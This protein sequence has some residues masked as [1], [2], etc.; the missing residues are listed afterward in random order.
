M[1]R[2][3][4]SLNQLKGFFSPRHIA[5][6]GAT[7][8]NQ[9]FGNIVANAIEAGFDGRFYPV[10]PRVD[11]IYGV[12]AYKS[13]AELPDGVIDCAILIV[14]SH[15]VYSVIRELREKHINNILL[16][17]SGFS[18]MGE[19]GKDKQD[20][21]RKYCT[22]HRIVLMGPNCLGFMNLREKISVFSGRAVEGELIPGSIGVVG[23]S[24]A[25][26]EVIVTKI[27]R[28][29]MGISLYVTTGNEAMILAE[30]CLEYLVH[31][32][33]TRVIAGFIEEFRDVEKLKR[34][35]LEA[36]AMKI[37]LI[38][39]KVG[40][41]DRGRKAALSHTGALAGNDRVL[42]GLFARYGIIRV[43][44]IEEMVETAVIFSR[45]PIPGGP[46]LG[47]CTFSG[48]LCGLYA[49][50]CDKYGIL[51]PPLEE[52][53]IARLKEHLPEFAVPGNP[54]DVTGAGFLH[55]MSET[56][57]ALLDDENLDVVAPVC[58]PPRGPDDVFAAVINES[59]LPL[60]D[61]ITKPIVPITFREMTD[62]GRDY[63]HKKGFYYIEHAEYG[64]KAISHLMKYAA[65]L[66][67]EEQTH[68]VKS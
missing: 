4:Y 25:T 47:I 9:W 40:R 62:Y 66:R 23:Q 22:D 16:V 38:M 36:A 48:G 37:P 50:L 51:L 46:G 15:L 63:F 67:R 34:V 18:E 61:T 17:S 5:I 49:D 27:L 7:P 55:G 56:I 41:S 14:K 44:S 12:R 45:C 30:D 3:P 33:H 53:T 42:E 26:S 31:D 54:L 8:N 13:I 21:I 28:K 10:N 64:L 58:I 39:L 43:D 29:G 19:E 57:H 60:M 6:V 1:K 32:E 68:G 24:G 59:F 65:F 2:T 35:A 20:E 11:E 52:K